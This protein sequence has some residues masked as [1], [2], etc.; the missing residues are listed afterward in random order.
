MYKN[1]ERKLVTSPYKK[2]LQDDIEKV[3][4]FYTLISDLTL[5]T[6]NSHALQLKLKW[7]LLA[8]EDLYSFKDTFKQE[9]DAL[10]SIVKKYN[11]PKK[12]FID[13]IEART[14]DC[15]LYPF[16]NLDNAIN[17]AQKTSGALWQVV[18]YIASCVKADNKDLKNIEK[19]GTL[20]GLAGL[21]RNA[22]YCKAHDRFT[23]SFNEESDN[24]KKIAEDNAKI[25]CNYIKKELKTSYKLQDKK[26][27]KLLLLNIFTKDYINQV[28]NANYQVLT[29]EF[30]KVSKP[31]L[32]RF[33]L[34]LVF[35]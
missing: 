34:G 7:Y 23:L 8:I 17:H 29:N 15:D 11:P 22:R 9:V 20:F 3:F 2:E 21:L 18:A 33:M 31:S 32:V 5:K 1:I 30:R 28:E 14:L 6:G 24:Y 4:N 35:G 16:K 13:M 27:K 19:V 26:L 12:L 10:Q 25:V